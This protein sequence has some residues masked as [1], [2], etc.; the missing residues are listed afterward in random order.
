MGDGLSIIYIEKNNE[1]S[2]ISDWGVQGFDRDVLKI[3][4]NKIHMDG[5]KVFEFASE[6]VPQTVNRIL[7]KNKQRKIDYIVLHQ[8]NKSINEHIMKKLNFKKEKFLINYDHGNLSASSIPVN[9]CKNFSNKTLIN[10][11]FMFV[12]F[13]SGLSWSSAI[14]KLI[15]VK[16]NRIKFYG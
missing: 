12:G 16:I 13:G 9:I 15:K 6:R 8:P 10:K 1:N 3:E 11:R 14:I 5:I 4:N 2:F 7:V